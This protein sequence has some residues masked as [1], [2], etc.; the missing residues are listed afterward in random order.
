MDCTK[1]VD[2][3]W[4]VK[5]HGERFF[6]ENDPYTIGVM[7]DSN[8]FGPTRIAIIT[9][10]I[11]RNIRGSNL[12][13]GCKY[14]IFNTSDYGLMYVLLDLMTEFLRSGSVGD[15]YGVIAPYTSNDYKYDVFDLVIQEFFKGGYYGLSDV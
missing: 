14:V 2:F 12:A 9:S 4:L 13:L 1:Y 6:Y 7:Y 10:N 8:S 11:M 3:G 15:L 5:D